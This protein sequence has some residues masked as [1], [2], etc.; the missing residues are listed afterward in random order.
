[1]TDDRLVHQLKEKKLRITQARKDIYQLLLSSDHSLSAKEIHLQIV[2]QKNDQV[3]D[4]VSVYRNLSLFTEMGLAH[5][6]Q[7]GRYSLCDH[8]N[9]TTPEKKVCNPTSHDHI[10]LINHCTSCGKS[11]EIKTHSKEICDL[12]LQI[13]KVSKLLQNYKEIIIQGQC[14]ECAVAP[15]KNQTL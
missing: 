4:L 13:K 14:A 6:F 15:Q 9:H 3:T 2:T 12:A 7:D 11:S 5:R 10:H 1:M 8:E